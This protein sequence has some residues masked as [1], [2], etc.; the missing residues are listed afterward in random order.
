LF[1]LFEISFSDGDDFGVEVF[2]G[3]DELGGGLIHLAVYLPMA[4]GAV[5]GLAVLVSHMVSEA[6]A[7][8]FADVGDAVLVFH[9]EVADKTEGDF[10]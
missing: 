3:F 5:G 9:R 2:E 10:L 1:C 7:P 4:A 8:V 6:D